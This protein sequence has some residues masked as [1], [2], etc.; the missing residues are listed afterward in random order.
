MTIEKL[1]RY[2]GRSPGYAYLP[3]ELRHRIAHDVPLW[4]E[5]VRQECERCGQPYVDMAD[6]FP[7]RLREV[8]AALTARERSSPVNVVRSLDSRPEV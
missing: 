5:F 3:E 7:Q 1:D 6:D 2:P 8:S 4:S